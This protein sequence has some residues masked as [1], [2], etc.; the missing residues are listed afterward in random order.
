MKG[1]LKSLHTIKTLVCTSDKLHV[2]K[3]KKKLWVTTCHAYSEIS[4]LQ[5]S[6]ILI[7]LSG[8]LVNPYQMPRPFLIVSQ[9]DYLIQIVDIKSH[10]E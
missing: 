5:I 10:A 6:D 9:S 3:D 8:G 1:L 2:A 4:R 7:F